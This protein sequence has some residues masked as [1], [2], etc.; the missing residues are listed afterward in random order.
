MAVFKCKMC[1]G[2]FCKFPVISYNTTKGNF[3]KPA[4]VGIEIFPFTSYNTGQ[5]KKDEQ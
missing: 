2:I 3:A 4:V 5:G 1:G